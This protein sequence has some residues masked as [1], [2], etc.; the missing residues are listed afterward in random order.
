M[1]GLGAPALQLS[2]VP[3]DVVFWGIVSL[4]LG[5]DQVDPS[6]HLGLPERLADAVENQ[7]LTHRT[8]SDCRRRRSRTISQSV[9]RASGIVIA[10][11]SSAAQR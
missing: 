6:E 8:P 2:W 11:K 7:Q 3:K 10:T 5:D 4:V 1:L 9:R